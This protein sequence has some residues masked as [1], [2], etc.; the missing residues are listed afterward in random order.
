M[1]RQKEI[2]SLKHD[3]I[4]ADAKAR[5]LRGV[6]NDTIDLRRKTDEEIVIIMKKHDLPPLSDVKQISNVDSY[7][8]LL[9]LRIDRV[10]AS[11]IEDAE[12]AV[13]K[14][15]ELLKQLESTNAS[16][17][18]LRELDEFEIAWSH[19]KDERMKLLDDSLKVKSKKLKK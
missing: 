12:K 8:Y 1:R 5:F 3:A 18:W 7:D 4:E 2:E 9:R 10:K 13:M 14:A 17:M 19:M 6:L 16:Q 11:A 15:Q